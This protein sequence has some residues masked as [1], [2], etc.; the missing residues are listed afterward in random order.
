MST[1]LLVNEQVFAGLVSFVDLQ[2]VLGELWPGVWAVIEAVPG[3]VCGGVVGV[4]G[5]EQG[6][7]GVASGSSCQADIVHH[8]RVVTIT[9]LAA[10]WF[11]EKFI[12]CTI[13]ELSRTDC[14]K[15]SAVTWNCPYCRNMYLQL[16]TTFSNDDFPKDHRTLYLIHQITFW[17]YSNHEDTEWDDLEII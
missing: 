12:E 16:S 15:L 14:Q 2:H 5:G 4:V 6:C 7:R 10:A 1:G 17:G 13:E 8:A 9:R 11:V 3:C